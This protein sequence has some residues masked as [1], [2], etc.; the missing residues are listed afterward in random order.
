MVYSTEKRSIVSN[1]E[2]LFRM[3]Q[4]MMPF[5]TGSRMCGG[6]NLAQMML[7]VAVVAI[8]RNFEIEAPLETN[9]RT[10]DIRDSFV[11]TLFLF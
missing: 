3:N 9:E 7:R 5:G 1:A 2:Q 11:N 8:V 6:Q 10:M 4:H